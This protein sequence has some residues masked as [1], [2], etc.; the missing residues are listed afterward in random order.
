MI[1]RRA[2]RKDAATL[3][4]CVMAL[5]REYGAVETNDI[6][7]QDF[8]EAG[9]GDDQMFEA[10]LAET[11]EGELRGAISFF[12]GFSGGYA[13]PTAYVHMLFI[14][15]EN[16]GQGVGRALLAKVAKLVVTRDW[17]R[18]ELLANHGGPAMPF[19]EAMGM[20]SSGMDYFCL[21][22]EKLKSF[23]DLT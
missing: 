3:F 13:K 20:D 19:Y 8:A 12:R 6:C 18:L 15:K 2:T 22:G 5:G 23:A 10:Y 16:R 17:V 21:D 11:E 4:D 1:I 9:F 7:A 14:T